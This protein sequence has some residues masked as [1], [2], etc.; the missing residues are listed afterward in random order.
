MSMELPNDIITNKKRIK[1]MLFITNALNN[2]WTVKKVNESYV[3]TKKHENLREVFK[4]N[5][6]ENF[7]IQSISSTDSSL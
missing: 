4:E 3:F 2:G 7:V 6:L 5:Y 1:K